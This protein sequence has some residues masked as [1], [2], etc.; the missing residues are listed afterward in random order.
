MIALLSPGN[1]KRCP[2]EKVY[3]HST[4][5]YSYNLLMK[6]DCDKSRWKQEP[7]RAK[8]LFE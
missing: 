3:M 1:I 7:S 4:E 6:E 8:I 2:R 5:K